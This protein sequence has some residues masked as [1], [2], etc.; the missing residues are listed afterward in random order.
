MNYISKALDS[1]L[2]LSIPRVAISA[3][4]TG[5]I[6]WLYLATIVKFFGSMI[7]S[8]NGSDFVD[9]MFSYIFTTQGIVS[10]GFFIIINCTLIGL[11]FSFIHNLI[12]K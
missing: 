12:S 4:I 9:L 6:Y 10:T 11:L 8:M 5:L 3:G 7:T 2:N 1:G